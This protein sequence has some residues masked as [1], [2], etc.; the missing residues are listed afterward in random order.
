M[1][2]QDSIQFSKTDKLGLGM[3]RPAC[4]KGR[5][6]TP[7]SGILS[8]ASQKK[9]WEEGVLECHLHRTKFHPDARVGALN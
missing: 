3:T 6:I 8:V 4:L 9:G 5:R 1:T 7:L 2:T